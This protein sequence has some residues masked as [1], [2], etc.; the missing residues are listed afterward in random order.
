VIV[1]LLRS[2]ELTHALRE[3]KGQFHKLPT[4]HQGYDNQEEFFAMVVQNTYASERKKTV[5]SARHHGGKLN[6]GRTEHFKS[7]QTGCGSSFGA[8]L[9]EDF[10][11]MLFHRRFTVRVDPLF[12]ADEPARASGASVTFEPG[13]RT[14]WHIIRSGQTLIVTAGCGWG[15]A[16]GRANRGGPSRRM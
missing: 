6:R 12:Q 8:E 3:M 2:D 11:D 14:A 4:R 1:S 15:A 7:A 5:L 16:R 10:E 9:F 13:A